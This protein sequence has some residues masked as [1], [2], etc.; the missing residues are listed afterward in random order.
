M[1]PT[2]G[3]QRFK[4]HKNQRPLFYLWLGE[5][6]QH[7]QQEQYR[8]Q[9][10][11]S[12]TATE[13]EVLT[14]INAIFPVERRGNEKGIAS[15][16]YESQ[17]EEVNNEDRDLLPTE[18]DEHGIKNMMENWTMWAVLRRNA[19][20][21]RA[22]CDIDS[23]YVINA[24]KVF[25]D[26]ISTSDALNKEVNSYF[27]N[28]PAIMIA[29]ELGYTELVEIM[30]SYNTCEDRLL[31]EIRERARELNNEGIVNFVNARLPEADV[32]TSLPEA[33]V[34]NGHTNSGGCVV[35]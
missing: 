32:G 5:Y 13:D 28:M 12:F 27:T 35:S 23:T 22:L 26:G 10:R 21:L 31:I 33:D 30:L 29:T 14:G 24:E 3:S 6:T 4:S 8:R 9:M 20:V 25:S 7:N 16:F 17:R 19:T 11:R 15:K 34:G 1:F 2:V 18:L